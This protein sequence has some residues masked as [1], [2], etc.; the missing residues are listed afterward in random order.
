MNRSVCQPDSSA[1][2]IFHPGKIVNK[3]TPEGY[4]KAMAL[5]WDES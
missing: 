5:D 1:Q 3:T 4:L 2:K